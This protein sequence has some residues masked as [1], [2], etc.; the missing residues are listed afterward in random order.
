MPVLDYL[1]EATKA[2]DAR[3]LNSVLSGNSSDLK[4]SSHSS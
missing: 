1:E 4:S 3:K 2:A